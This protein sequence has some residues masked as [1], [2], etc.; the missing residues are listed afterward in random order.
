MGEKIRTL[1][2][3]EL[4]GQNFE[5]EENFPDKPGLETD[6]HIQSEN[7]R[8]QMS[9][10]EFMRFAAVIAGAGKQLRRLKGLEDDDL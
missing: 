2:K 9:R 7:S 8:L 3:I 1:G 5:V 6:F 4:N 10:S